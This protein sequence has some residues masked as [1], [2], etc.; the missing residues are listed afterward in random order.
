M[1]MHTCIHIMGGSY[2]RELKGILIGDQKVLRKATRTCDPF[3]KDDYM[4]IL[5][6]PFMVTRAAG[7]FGVDLVA[8]RGDVSFPIEVKASKHH[9]LHFSDS[10][11]LKEQADRMQAEC[12]K[13]KVVPIYAFRLKSIQGDSWRIFTMDME[14]LD[15]VPAVVHRR[16]PRLAVTKSGNYAMRWNEGLPLA[17]FIAYLCK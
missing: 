7:S 17:E 15:G 2:E 4:K 11:R 5:K 3:V 9:I 10:P 12:Q 13:A 16:I 1:G 14:G 6:W 8:I